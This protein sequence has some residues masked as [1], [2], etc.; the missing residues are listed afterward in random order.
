MQTKIE[1]ILGFNTSKGEDSESVS[2]RF[3]VT[4]DAPE[5]AKMAT[6]SLPATLSITIPIIRE[7]R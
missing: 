6:G 7:R 4:A 3:Y 5:A 2:R 1:E